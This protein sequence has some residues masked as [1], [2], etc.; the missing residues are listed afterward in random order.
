[1][2]TITKGICAVGIALI[3]T[4]SGAN[5][6]TG[7]GTNGLVEIREGIRVFVADKGQGEPVLMLHGGFMDSSMWDGDAKA[8]EGRYR[9][10]RY[11]MRGYGR[12]PASPAPYQPT[13][14]IVALLDHLKIPKVHVVGISMGGGLAVDFALAHPSRVGSLFLAEPGLSGW[15]WS[16]EV[17]GTMQTVMNANKVRGREGAIEEFL[18]QPVF[19]SAADKPDAIAA[20]RAQLQRNFSLEPRGAQ[21]PSNPAIDRL[22][23]IACPTVVLVAERGGPDARLIG[24]RF[25]R[26]VA[27]ARVIQVKGTGHMI[28]LEAPSAFREHLE[29]FLTRHPLR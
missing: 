29:N 20:I 21:E 27:G 10:I 17:S 4:I 24:D 14:D 12:S 9:I 1:M 15:R 18:K 26:E 8:L 13:D 28:N 3:G 19:A 2:R 23:E 7:S 16:S 6:Q 5:A 22:A 25:Q 11:D